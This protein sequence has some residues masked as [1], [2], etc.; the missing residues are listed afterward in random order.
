M[1]SGPGS[2]ERERNRRVLLILT[3][4]SF[5]NTLKSGEASGQILGLSHL[6]L[7]LS[8][9]TSPSLSLSLSLCHF[10]TISNK[11]AKRK[12]NMEKEIEIMID[13]KIDLFQLS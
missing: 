1:L 4:A 2:G 12:T 6:T 7:F 11:H 9:S 3:G 13:R 8:P 5:V 10:R